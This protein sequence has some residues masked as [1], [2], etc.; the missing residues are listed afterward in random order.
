[1]QILLAIGLLSVL[2][3][4]P[5]FV[6]AQRRSET[7]MSSPVLDGLELPSYAFVHGKWFNGE[8]FDLR[9]VYAVDDRLTFQKPKRID[10]TLDPKGTYVI[11]PFGKLTI[12][13]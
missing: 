8:S 4:V 1:M 13:I 10:K 5:L 11:P 9:T 7:S 2:T 12:T 3:V 6:T